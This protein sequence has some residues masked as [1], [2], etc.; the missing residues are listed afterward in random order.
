M[1]TSAKFAAARMALGKD[2]DFSDSLLLDPLMEV[3]EDDSE[4]S[5]ESQYSSSTSSSVSVQV[6]QTAF[7]KAKT[8]VVY[9]GLAGG[10]VASALAC[11]A[12]PVVTVFVM[13]GICVANAP[14]AAFKEHRIIKVPALRSLNNK[15]RGDANRLEEV[16]DQVSKSIDELEP[17]AERAKI[18]EEELKAI[19]DEQ[20]VNVDKL[21]DLVKENAIILAEMKRNLKQRVVQDILKIVMLSDVNNDGTFSKVETKMLVLKIRVA[22]HEYGIEFDENKF[23]LL[24]KRNPS[25]TQTFSIVKRLLPIEDLDDDTRMSVLSGDRQASD[26]SFSDESRNEDDLYDMFR[27]AGD[28][29]VSG[30][31]I[32][33]SIEGR[34]LS[35]NLTKESDYER[36]L[37]ASSRLLSDASAVDSPISGEGSPLEANIGSR[38]KKLK[39][40]M[41]AY[42]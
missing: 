22:L 4:Y 19:A 27:S 20:Q 12:S 30:S 42:R 15:L 35:L 24:M 10:V 32:G 13:A 36:R 23:Y 39:P 1:A 18:V 29:S 25:V 16:V 7:Q 31:F 41:H 11:V 9:L 34:R 14:F 38:R 33:S 40:Q 6:Q 17:E 28:G 2:F 8:F 21:V 26:E 5:E 3:D 37:R